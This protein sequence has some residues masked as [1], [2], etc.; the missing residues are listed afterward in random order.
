[1]AFG[2]R[3]RIKDTDKP[4]P[5]RFFSSQQEKSVAKAVSGQRQPNSGATMWAPGDVVAGKFLVECKTKMTD[6]K[7][8]SIQKEWF[9][10]NT[11]E[12]V[13]RGLPYGIV[14][15]NFGPNQKMYYIIDENLMIDF[16]DYMNTKNEDN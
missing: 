5:T 16:I 13:F 15:F 7:S 11:R 14:A 9:E 6:S 8:I 1:M 10:K 3:E 2:L 4:K 12:A